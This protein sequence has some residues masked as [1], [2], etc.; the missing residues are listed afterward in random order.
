MIEYE[1]LET[2]KTAALPSKL[3]ATAQTMQNVSRKTEEVAMEVDA[4]S[5]QKVQ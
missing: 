3:A 5:P 1:S 2:T 4:L